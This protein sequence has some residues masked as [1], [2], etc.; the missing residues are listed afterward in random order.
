MWRKYANVGQIEAVGTGLYSTLSTNI[1]H[2][3]GQ[4]LVLDGQWNTLESDIMKALVPVPSRLTVEGVDWQ[5]EKE[6][7]CIS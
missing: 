7:Y 2:F 6:R 1:H 3:S 5:R 4:F